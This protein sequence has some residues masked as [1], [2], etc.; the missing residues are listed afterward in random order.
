[1]YRRLIDHAKIYEPPVIAIGIS[2][3][4]CSLESANK[5]EESD[6]EIFNKKGKP[7]KKPKSNVYE[8]VYDSEHLEGA[9]DI[10]C[11]EQNVGGN[12]IWYQ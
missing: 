11:D 10:L 8:T 1:M 7:I 2:L 12:K 3:S 6:E 5:S 4:S 9:S